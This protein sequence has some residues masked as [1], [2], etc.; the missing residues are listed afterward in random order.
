MP[1]ETDP[2]PL[3]SEIEAFLEATGMPLTRFG[4]E[5]VG[6]STL[7]YDLRRGRDCKRKT[8][9]RIQR[10]IEAQTKAA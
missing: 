6:D 3:L 2:D 10:Y 4:V 7:V 5:A 8:R 1:S 9:L